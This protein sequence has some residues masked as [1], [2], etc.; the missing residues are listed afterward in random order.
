MSFVID[1]GVPLPPSA[2]SPR[3]SKYP[4]RDMD[5]G[6]S[7]FVPGVPVRNLSGRLI[8]PARRLGYKVATRSWSENGVAGVRVWRVE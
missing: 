8:N 1:K 4:L 7:F 2:R 3:A 6:D 5:V